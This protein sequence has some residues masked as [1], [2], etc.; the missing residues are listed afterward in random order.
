[1]PYR[2]GAWPQWTEGG[3]R[4]ISPNGPTGTCGS[5][6]FLAVYN[7]TTPQSER[8]R[9]LIRRSPA[10]IGMRVE[11]HEDRVEAGEV[12]LGLGP[13]FDAVY[14]APA[15][16]WPELVDGCLERML[17]MVT[18]GT[19]ELDGPIEHLLDRVYMR[20]RPVDGSPEGWW[21]YAREVAPGLLAVLALDYPD[22]IAILNDDQVN[23]HGLERLAEVGL[24]NLCGQLPDTY[25][26][27]D[28]VYL[29]S[30]DDYVGSTVLVMPWVVQAVTGSPDLLH[31]V[32]VAM[33]NHGTLIFHILNDA[34]GAQYAMGEIA[35]LA[36]ECHEDTPGGPGL[37]SPNVYWWRP[38][39]TFLE[40]VAHHG[41]GNG[42]IGEDL[43]TYYSA[44]F[45]DM[46]EQLDR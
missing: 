31:G 41:D 29:I 27:S 32:L 17:G 12:V 14:D 15:E 18:G 8:L 43:V 36:A 13:V 4:R 1:M 21:N 46:L 45:A 28:G 20:L 30:G 26:A 16:L 42:V 40:P 19:S 38:G 35:R 37:L 39:A 2:L 10:F 33:P 11:L 7:L 34:A 25:A 23:R 3:F 6:S 22:R 44:D 5:C 9:N 24:D